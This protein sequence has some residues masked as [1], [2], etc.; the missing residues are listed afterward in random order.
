MI[1][2]K[3]Q[4]VKHLVQTYQSQEHGFNFLEN[5]VI[6]NHSFP[7]SPNIGQRV[8]LPIDSTDCVIFSWRTHF[9]DNVLVL[10]LVVA[11]I[12]RER[13][14]DIHIGTSLEPNQLKILEP[15]FVLPESPTEKFP[16]QELLIPVHAINT[17]INEDLQIEIKLYDQ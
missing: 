12:I 16:R 6:L 8:V 13:Q 4:L 7:G 11:S 17:G 1:R 3:H 5:S 10:D 14:L 9:D 15:C 2:P